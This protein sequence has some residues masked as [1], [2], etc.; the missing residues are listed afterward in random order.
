MQ[1]PLLTR[2]AS[3]QLDTYD[4]HVQVAKKCKELSIP[5]ASKI[6]HNQ[7]MS[8]HS[9]FKVAFNLSLSQSFTALLLKG[10]LIQYNPYITAKHLKIRLPQ[11]IPTS[12][13]KIISSGLSS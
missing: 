4:N 9:A 2:Q 7:A 8:I 10:N 12:H 6:H 1:M 11:T 13:Q 5:L 3:D